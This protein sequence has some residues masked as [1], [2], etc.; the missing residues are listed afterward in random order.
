M[1]R[2]I[3]LNEK[4]LE[5]FKMVFDNNGLR[6]DHDYNHFAFFGAFRC[7]KSFLMMLISLMLC[8]TYAGCNGSIVRM[9]YGELADSCIVQYL[10][11]F[12]PDEYGYQYKT[13]NREIIFSNDYVPL[14]PLNPPQSK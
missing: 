3:K 12:P 7:G 6:T 2:T 13:A 1:E 10:E 9:T 4:Q 8:Q 11:A 5:M 14:I